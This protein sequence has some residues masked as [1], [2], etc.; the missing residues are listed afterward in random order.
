ML[1]LIPGCIMDMVVT[2]VLVTTMEDGEDT[3]GED[4]D[5]GSL[6][7]IKNTYGRCHH[8]FVNMYQS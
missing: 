7:N 3:D 6:I 5:S 2:M 1:M 4:T 8:C